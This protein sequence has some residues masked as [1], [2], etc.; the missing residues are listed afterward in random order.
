VPHFHSAGLEAVR[1][2]L[3]KCF[4]GPNLPAIHRGSFGKTLKNRLLT[5]RVQFRTLINHEERLWLDCSIN[6]VTA[7]DRDDGKSQHG[8]WMNITEAIGYW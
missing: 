2:V 1:N 6:G 5:L 4:S 8:L 3:P 7:Y